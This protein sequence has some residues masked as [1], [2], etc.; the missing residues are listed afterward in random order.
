MA[1][2][3]LCALGLCSVFTLHRHKC[4]NCGN[5]A[6]T[7]EDV[8]H[9]SERIAD[10]HPFPRESYHTHDQL[11]SPWHKEALDWLGMIAMIPLAVLV[12]AVMPLAILVAGVVSEL[13]PGR[14]DH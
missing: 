10:A 13:R 6:I 7:N 3:F 2:A 12:S 8:L 1:F 4:D 9:Y 11:R 14:T 5:T